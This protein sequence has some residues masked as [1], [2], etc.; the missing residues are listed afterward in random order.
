MKKALNN[1]TLKDSC[2]L[3]E[4]INKLKNIIYQFARPK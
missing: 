2:Q 3:V 4:N 1:N